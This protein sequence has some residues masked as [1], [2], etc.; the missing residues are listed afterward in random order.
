MSGELADSGVRRLS[1]GKSQVSLCSNISSYSILK[2]CVTMVIMDMSVPILF[3]IS[4]VVEDNLFKKFSC[5][6]I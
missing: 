6:G 5:L 1:D 2:D 3:I 4:S